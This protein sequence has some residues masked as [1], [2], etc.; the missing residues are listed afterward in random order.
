[1]I[2]L[3]KLIRESYLFAFQA[4]I[5]NKVRT[6]LSLLG[7]TIGIFSVIA[8]LT[9]FNSME[10][11][12]R[13]SLSE[14]GDNVLF[15]QK[16]PWS[17]GGNY[18]W[19]KYLNRPEP[20]I[21][22]MVDIQH[23]SQTAESVAMMFQTN[24]TVKRLNNSY[25]DVNVFGVSH[26]YDR[27]FPMDIKDGR[28]FTQLESIGGRNVVIIGAGIAENLFENEYPIGKS[29]KIFGN[30]VTVI[31]ILTKQ[32]EG[33]FGSSTDEQVFVPM[34]FARNYINMRN[35]GT[36]IL[37][38]AKPNVGNIQLKDE[39]TGIMRSVRKI[40]PGEENN[41]ALNELS[42]IDQGLQ[43]FFSGIAVIGWI[44]GAFSLLVGGFGIA[45]IMFVSVRERTNI[46]GIKKAIGAKGFFILL[47]FLFEAVFLS[48]IGGAV[49]LLLIFIGTIIF[50]DSLGFDLFL[51]HNNILLGMVISIVIGLI[52]GIVPA[53]SASR[54]DPVEAIRFGV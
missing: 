13:G 34:N 54:L 5:V 32:G 1:M 14:L 40:K 50:H 36:T 18:P 37:V 3:L 28:Y 20:G 19:W 12:I 4:I 23:R 7:I 51:S 35:I 24:R 22:E 26:Q 43:S 30:K 45:N 48:L 47:E 10:T 46:I 9:V 11:S 29:I 52:A 33:S 41:F 6:I 53:W 16:W 42:V 39:I 49:G 38:R 21:S 31:G 8:V 27:V 15:I 44:I 25:D 2:L 17:M